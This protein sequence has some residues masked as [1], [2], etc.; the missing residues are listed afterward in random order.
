MGEESEPA[1]GGLG[2]S[3]GASGSPREVAGG[4][5]SSGEAP[6][7]AGGPGGAGSSGEAPK[8][9]KDQPTIILV[10]GAVG[11]MMPAI[12]PVAWYLAVQYERDC[13]AAGVVPDQSAVAGKILGII[14]T[15]LLALFLL[16]FVV[17]MVLW[18]LMAVFMVLYFVVVFG[19]MLLLM[20]VGAA[21]AAV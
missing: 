21:G 18:I 19:F 14:G 15:V 11:L 9:S 1:Q 7:H 3:G 5:G 17:F 16:A 8:V 2:T 6:E 4:A 12:A 13:R 10:L 20:V